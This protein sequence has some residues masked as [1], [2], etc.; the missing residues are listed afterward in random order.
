MGWE[1]RNGN[2]YYYRKRRDGKRVTSVYVGNGCIG[3]IAEAMD[4]DERVE[5]RQ[6]RVNWQREK[7]RARAIDDRLN[8]IER[9]VRTFTRAFLLVSGYHPH[10]RQWRRKRNG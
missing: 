3:Q 10:K 8:E 5:N 2:T 9:R 6:A 1:N 4:M 7:E